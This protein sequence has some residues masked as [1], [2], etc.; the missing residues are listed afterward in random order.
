MLPHPPTQKARR[1]PRL[2]DEE[3]PVRGLR[4]MTRGE[5][6]IARSRR[7]H[8]VPCA[9]EPKTEMTR[10]NQSSEK[11]RCFLRTDDG[12]QR[13]TRA[14]NRRIGSTVAARKCGGRARGCPT[15][16]S[17]SERNS[18]T[19]VVEQ[20]RQDGRRRGTPFGAPTGGSCRPIASSFAS[21]CTWRSTALP[22]ARS[23]AGVDRASEANILL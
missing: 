20:R 17:V 12:G 10:P 18:H 19:L 4:Q 21:M 15:L 5:N 8:V 14:P 11:R 16:G 3:R 1:R 7:D 13:S 9:R 23:R 22:R 2:S 6:Q